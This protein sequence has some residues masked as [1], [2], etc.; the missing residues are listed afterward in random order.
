MS[1][2]LFVIVARLGMVSTEQGFETLQDCLVAAAEIDAR[3]MTAIAEQDHRAWVRSQVDRYD[4]HVPLAW[5]MMNADALA[6]EALTRR[7]EDTAV[8]AAE[9]RLGVDLA[10]PAMTLENTKHL[11]EVVAA[12]PTR[13]ARIK[14]SLEE[15]VAAAED[16]EAGRPTPAV[17]DATRAARHACLPKMH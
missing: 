12:S 7:S 6:E 4:G 10:R 11:A 14:A 17:D 2:V 3:H 16:R 8:S 9:E 5:A 13:A 15:I 1:W